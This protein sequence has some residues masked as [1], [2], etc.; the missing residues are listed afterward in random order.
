MIIGIGINFKMCICEYCGKEHDGTYGSGRFCSKTCRAKYV[1]SKVKT[2]KSNWPKKSNK[3]WICKDCGIIFYTRN[4]L[5]LHRKKYHIR[6][7]NEVWNKGLTKDNN[8]SLQQASAVLKEKF[9]SGKLKSKLSGKTYEEIYG[10]DKANQIKEKISKK[11]SINN[12]GGRCK[13]F[14]Y[15]NQ[16][17]QGTWELNIAKKLEAEKIKWIKCTKN[18]YS[19][20]YISDRIHYYTPDFYL[21]EY[22]IYLEIKGHWWGNDKQKMDLV[23]KQ[24]QNIK[25][26][27]IENDLYEDL[28]NNKISIRE[29]W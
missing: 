9:K 27:I 2:H 14:M 13:W 16:K 15:L 4:E 20:K 22:D 17:L 19:L 8:Y 26:I 29:L 21:P 25:L 10:K 7:N 18:K 3:I 1:A 23:C 12:K 5:Y 11:L 28:I 6:N 24:N